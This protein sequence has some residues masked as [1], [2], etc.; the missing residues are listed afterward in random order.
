MSDPV[1]ISLRQVTR[2]LGIA[3]EKVEAVV[4][5]LDDGNTIPFIARYRKDQTGGLDEE[6]IRD[7]QARL[8]KL[9][10]LAERKQ[11]V[12]R[13]IESQDKLTESLEKRVREAATLKRLEDLYLPY[14]PKKT[15]LATA[16]RAKGLEELA[17]EILESSPRCE[18]LDARAAEFI[19]EERGVATAADALLGA[20]HIIAE[21]LSERI[22]LRQRLR[23]VVQKSG[24][25]VSNKSETKPTDVEIGPTPKKKN[26]KK[27]SR[28][29]EPVAAPEKKVPAAEKPVVETKPESTDSPV[30]ETPEKTEP[31]ET[32]QVTEAPVVE[33][34]VVEAPVE[35]TPVVEA[36]VE[37]ASVE[38]PI[39]TPVV[40]E[41]LPEEA[42][43]TDEGSGAG[44]GDDGPV[45]EDAPAD[46]PETSEPAPQED[47]VEAATTE[48]PVEEKADAETPQAATPQEK[49]PQEETP[50]VEPVAAVP[51]VEEKAA[52]EAESPAVPETPAEE[53]PSEEE[54][55][56]AVEESVKE[57][58]PT[59]PAA[60]DA[61]SEP[62]PAT[63]PKE[64]AT[65][66]KEGKP[67]AKPA[68]KKPAKQEQK[69][70]TLSEAERRKNKRRKERERRKRRSHEKKLEAFANYF[71]FEEELRK[72]PPHR[73]LALNRGERANL[74]RIKI[75][76]DVEAMT[77]V[78]DELCI[79]V[80][81]PH[82]EFLRG[83]AK[84]A[85]ARLLVPSLEREVRRELTDRAEHHAV[86]VFA[87]N[88]RNLLLQTPIKN[89]R[90]LAID[91]GLKHGCKMAALDQF[92]NVLA[93]DTVYLIGKPEHKERAKTTVLELIKHFQLTAIVIGNGTGCREAETFI[94]DMIL[95]E[96][97]ETDMGYVVV[98]EAGASVYSTSPLGREEFPEYD[99]LLRGAIS[100]G[101]RIQDPL[102]ELVKID[103]AN[104]GVGLYQH[105]VKAKHLK[106]SLDGVVESCVNF[107]GVDVNTASPSLLRYVS[108]LNQLTA[109]RIYEHRLANGPFRNR[110][111]LLDVSGLGEASFVQAAG[112]LKIASG[113]NPLDATW[114]H[115]ESYEIAQRVL[116][117][118]EFS[119]DDLGDKAKR[120]ELKKKIASVRARELAEELEVGVLLLRDI[121]TQLVRPGRDPREDLPAPIFKKGVL[122]LDDLEPGME[123]NGTVLNVVDFGAFVDIGMHDS[124]LVH[125]S[126]LANRFIRDAHDVVAV[127]DIVHIWVVEVDKERR[128]VSLTMIDPNAEKPRPEEHRGGRRDDHGPERS[129]PSERGDR[130]QG[131]RPQGDRSRG[132]NRSQ[133]S[134][135]QG[136]DRGRRSQD[137]RGRRGGGGR[138]PRRDNRGQVRSNRSKTFELKPREEVKKKAPLS[139]DVKAGA[140][141]MRSFG[142]LALFFGQSEEKKNPKSKG[143]GGKKKSD[144]PTTPPKKEE[145]PKDKPDDKPVEKPPVSAETQP[146][147]APP[148]DTVVSN[149][150]PE[151][152]VTPPVEETSPKDEGT[153]ASE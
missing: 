28:R 71:G 74:L 76:L 2:G 54:K 131:D 1:T 116:E 144:K 121:L 115:P 22:D 52:E 77:G 134:G 7:I 148:T 94:S 138:G 39:E 106:D 127:G 37:E 61:S 18:D 140:E 153:T 64:E 101:R 91:P 31:V 26:S 16:A 10:Q 132:D 111:Q 149:D 75:E 42:P 85:L 102:S 79:P 68:K 113:D 32:A 84:D 40:E 72:I 11:T 143:R 55:P 5:L 6:Q 83:C 90:V 59:E 57:E 24:K 63:T 86:S 99:A 89:R 96:L 93:H 19:S 12:L 108:G 100:I 15:T 118:L 13:S 62:T 35:E 44:G 151:V 103:P 137:D 87:K 21:L 47:P 41:T 112:F 20:G 133:G 81:H 60:S 135:S 92:G 124:G 142:D 139:E 34:P 152:N 147:L 73:V 128:R 109:R 88:L 49:P 122:T 56:V 119:L 45:E 25:V 38:T 104:I 23:D 14:K 98:N 36:P 126:Q 67:A 30:E 9:R 33:A 65:A 105:D 114:I 150:S 136:G 48:T 130:P 141:P 97:T 17:Q 69:Q 53:T 107:V 46:S 29:A 95:T 58:K 117:K 43:K 4:S 82:A 125:I 70:P 27:K 123:L 51:P 120:L 80:E 8:L 3:P 78:S 50:P 110:R 146:E 66:P 145:K 129:G